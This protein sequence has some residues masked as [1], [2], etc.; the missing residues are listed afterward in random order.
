M[1]ILAWFSGNCSYYP[2]E[3]TLGLSSGTRPGS[4]RPGGRRARLVR[5]GRGWRLGPAW[6]QE[7]PGAESPATPLR[8]V[9][10]RPTRGAVF[11]LHTPGSRV[12]SALGKVSAPSP[13]GPQPGPGSRSREPRPGRNRKRRPPARP[14]LP[15]PARG[16]GAAL[17][18]GGVLRWGGRRAGEGSAA[19]SPRVPFHVRRAA[20]GGAMDLAGLLLDE[21]G[22]FS[23]TGFQD[24]TVRGRPAPSAACRY[25]SSDPGR[26]PGYPCGAATSPD[27]WVRKP[28]G[29]RSSLAYS[30]PGLLGPRGRARGR[31]MEIGLASRGPARSTSPA[32]QS[33]AEDS[34]PPLCHL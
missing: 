25:L 3:D 31:G 28:G 33:V 18:K 15:P 16:P 32:E 30:R 1:F 21:E 23:V 34:C 29:S 27:R 10:A 6:G 4:G 7:V 8:L 2:D 12:Y 20:S 22:T 13:P 11:W 17:A 14:R 26:S 9:N 24:F 5:G 19:P